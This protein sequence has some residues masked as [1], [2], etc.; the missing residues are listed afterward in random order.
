[1][2]TEYFTDKQV[3]AFAQPIWD[4]ICEGSNNVDYDKFSRY[5][6]DSLKEMVT[7]DVF[8]YQC[9]VSSL[10]TTLGKATPV[11]CIRR[12]DGY[13]VIFKQTSTQFPGEFVGLLTL[14]DIGEDAFV[15]NVQVI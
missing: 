12:E 10:L 3:F 14:S 11:A 8:E 1:M 6:S 4:S 7:K 15:E 5:F 2:A 9:D 13:S